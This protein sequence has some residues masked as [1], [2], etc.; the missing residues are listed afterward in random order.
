MLL[1][2]LAF[3]LSDHTPSTFS[4]NTAKRHMYAIDNGRTFYCGCPHQDK[5]PNLAECGVLANGSRSERTE[6][7]HVVPASRLGAGRECWVTGGRDGC[8][9]ADPVFKAAHNDLHNL[10]PAVGAINASRSDHPFGEVKGETRAF[11]NV[12]DI[13]I[14]DGRVEPPVE[15]RGD[16]ARVSFYME[17]RYGVHWSPGERA[18]LLAWHEA[19]PVDDDERQRN[20]A[21]AERQGVANPWID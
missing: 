20:V 8:L 18:M 14:E 1:L 17:W 7:E 4:F 21:V 5:V 11:G 9:K 10:R 12:C 16:I 3:T 6:A 13:E 2:L 19:D 15:V